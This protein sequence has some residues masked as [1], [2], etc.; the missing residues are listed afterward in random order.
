MEEYK[1][2]NPDES[3]DSSESSEEEAD[4]AQWQWQSENGWVD[5]D[6][7][8]SGIIEAAHKKG[9]CGRFCFL[10]ESL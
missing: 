5:Y 7:E 9:L 4:E 1:A 8:T 3:S 2:K 6:E 10:L